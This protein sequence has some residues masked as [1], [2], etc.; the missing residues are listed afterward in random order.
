MAVRYY[1]SVAPPTTLSEG[2]TSGSTSI[3]VASTTGFPALTPYTL[4]I[5]YDTS[6]EE[7]VQV[8]TAGGTTLTVDRGIDGT[9]ATSHTA[10]VQV[11]HVTSARDFADSRTH[12]NSANGVHGLSPTEELV[13]TEKAQTLSNKTLDMAT[14]TLDR[15]DIFNTAS[16]GPGSWVTTVN[17]DP[18]TPTAS[19]LQVR[20]DPSGQPLWDVEAR[21]I[22][23]MQN[24]A[25]N[26]TNPNQYKLRIVKNDGT[27]DVYYVSSG[28]RVT[29]RLANGTDG[30][31]VVGPPDEVRRRA[32][33]AVDT[34]GA[35]SRVALHT[36]G[37]ALF[38]SRSPAQRTMDLKMAPGQ[39]ANPLFI[40]SSADAEVAKI[41]PTGAFTGRAVVASESVSSAAYTMTPSGLPLRAIQVGVQS[42]T[43]NVQTSWTVAVTFPKPFPSVPLVFTNI[44]SGIGATSRWYSRAINVTTTGFTMFVARGSA[45]DPAVDWS[46]VPVQWMATF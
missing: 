6:T 27:S 7:L 10:G 37:T 22:M 28:G 17:G 9:S 44:N 29:T 3:K 13:G 32:F 14:G 20:A 16:P 19:I 12:E 24:T 11:R 30:M 36:D 38:T 41:D 2:I 35:T 46:N 1:S 4:A 18:A 25:V 5:S 45:D 40:R 21:G 15:I 34:D 33:S 23:K 43:F 31:V 42:I 26:D 8:N 39:T